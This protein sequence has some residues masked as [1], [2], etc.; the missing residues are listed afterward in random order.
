MWWRQHKVK[1]N[2]FQTTQQRC[3]SLGEMDAPPPIG[4]IATTERSHQRRRETREKGK[5]VERWQEI[6]SLL[7]AASSWHDRGGHP[8]APHEVEPQ[9]RRTAGECSR[10]GILLDAAGR[11][12]ITA[13]MDIERG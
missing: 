6:P 4:C 13:K 12:G 7:L 1:G 9:Q 11:S 10:V 3:N 8:G 5:K 2:T